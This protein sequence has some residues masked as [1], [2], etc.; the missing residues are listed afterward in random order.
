[1]DF[2]G[3]EPEVGNSC[4]FG[5]LCFITGGNISAVEVIPTLDQIVVG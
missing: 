4:I 1:M 5:A 3:A 2:A